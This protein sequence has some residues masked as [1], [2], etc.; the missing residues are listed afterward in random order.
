M[1]MMITVPVAVV[2]V[3]HVVDTDV[4][5][6]FGVGAGVDVISDPDHDEHVDLM[7]KAATQCLRL[8]MKGT[9]W[10]SNSSSTGANHCKEGLDREGF[11]MYR[12]AHRK[13]KCV[14]S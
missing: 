11:D 7:M 8:M 13:E 6:G 2:E 5:V 10:P 14:Q 9:T 12:N 4:D 1:S 3:D